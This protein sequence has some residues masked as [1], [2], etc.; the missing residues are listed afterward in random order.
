VG[1]VSLFSGLILDSVAKG[2]REA[3]LLAYLS[4]ASVREGA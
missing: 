4:M 2:R 1:I 3:K